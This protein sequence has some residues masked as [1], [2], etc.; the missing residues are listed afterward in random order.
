MRG[1]DEYRRKLP[2]LHRLA[3]EL[4]DAID[5][6]EYWED[7]AGKIERANPDV[8]CKDLEKEFKRVVGQS[9]Y[10]YSEEIA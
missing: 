5:A 2:V 9:V 7:A 10:D 4:Q 8:D 3:L 6:G 1:V